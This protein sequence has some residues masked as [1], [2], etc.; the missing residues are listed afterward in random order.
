[1]HT[2]SQD[3]KHLNRLIKRLSNVLKFGALLFGIYLSLGA[4]NLVPGAV[5]FSTAPV[6][7]GQ[8]QSSA[9]GSTVTINPSMPVTRTLAPPDTGCRLTAFHNSPWSKIRPSGVKSV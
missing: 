4:C 6:Y 3:R 7:P 2:K 1:M 9:A 8:D 5:A